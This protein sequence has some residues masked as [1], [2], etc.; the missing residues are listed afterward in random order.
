MIAVAWALVWF[1]PEEKLRSMSGLQA[2][3]HD[4]TKAAAPPS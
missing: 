1:L 4:A 2:R 3:H